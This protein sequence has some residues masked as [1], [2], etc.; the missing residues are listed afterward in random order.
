LVVIFSSKYLLPFI[1]EIS[2]KSR[3]FLFLSAVAVCFFFSM[4]AHFFG[5][6]IVIGAFLAGLALSSLPYHFDIAGR[7]IPLRDFF[8]ILFFVS[9]G[10]ELVFENIGGMLVLLLISL[11]VILLL[12]PLILMI[13]GSILGY[14]KRTSFLSALSLAQISEFSLI[15]VALGLNLGHVSN[16][17]FTLTVLL[18]VI[19]IT[20]TSYFIKYDNKIYGVF[21]KKLDIFEKLA[22]KETEL[23][24]FP[25]HSKKD[26]VLF[27]AHRMGGVFINTFNKF[28]EKLVVVDFDPQVIIK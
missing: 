24:H 6:S 25:Y 27:G 4:L 21:S 12:K 20:L 10:M 16:K 11:V 2:A 14:K 15:L 9:L 8:V 23:E 3:E 7:I 18:A 5:F 19:T 28:K 26:I 1:F 22:V 17:I 13:M